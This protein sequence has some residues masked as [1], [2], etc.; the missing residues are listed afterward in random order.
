[1]KLGLRFG[2]AEPQRD[3]NWWQ[4]IESF[5]VLILYKK[6]KWEFVMWGPD[7]SHR[8]EHICHFSEV[9]TYDPNWYATT[10]F[11]IEQLLNTGYGSK[12]ECG[13][14]YTSF[15]QIHMFFCPKWFKWNG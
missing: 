15:P 7:P 8:V 4:P 10:Y 6:A 11:D 3:V 2:L 1:M 12:C 14:A 5:P 13:A 9:Q